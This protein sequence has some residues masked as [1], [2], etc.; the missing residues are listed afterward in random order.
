MS[1]VVISYG[2][3]WG[4]GLKEASKEA[5]TVSRRLADY[6]DALNDE[7]YKKL[8]NYAGDRNENFNSALNSIRAKITQLEEDS[9]KYE[10]YSADID[11]LKETCKQVDQTVAARVESLTEEFKEANGITTSKFLDNI[12]LFLTNVKNR[13]FIGR[14]LDDAKDWFDQTKDY[15]K[16]CIED[17]YQFQ[18]GEQYLYGSGEAFL[19]MALAVGTLLVG[20]ATI[21]AGGPAI[22]LIGGIAGVILGVIGIINSLANGKNEV[23]ALEEYSDDPAK[24]RRLSGEDTVQDYLRQEG[25]K[26]I[27]LRD[28]IAGTIDA[29]T[30]VCEVAKIA[31]GTV[32]LRSNLKSWAG[33][34]GIWSKIK[35]SAIS[36]T[37]ELKNAF[38]TNNFTNITS[39]LKNIAIR[40]LK[41]NYLNADTGK[42]LGYTI[43]NWASLSKNALTDVRDWKKGDF[44][45]DNMKSIL[46]TLAFNI[47][48]VEYEKSNSSNGRVEKKSFYLSKSYELIKKGFSISD[49]ALKLFNSSNSSTKIAVPQSILPDAHVD[50]P[51]NPIKIDLSGLRASLGY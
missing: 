42:D 51:I 27:A 22:V 44:G 23:R 26:N 24:A 1:G 10:T 14:W 16:E 9:D 41:I 31:S 39:S 18:G 17:W 30:I 15:L 3:G 43:Q 47:T 11:D 20:A 50:V 34:Q 35:T 28:G 29:V 45:S 12:D 8:N 13:T 46:E 38:A 21:A 33:E 2:D 32:A 37:N 19:K 40:N 4:T 49:D 36:G 48:T 5:K 6:A 25:D 7:V